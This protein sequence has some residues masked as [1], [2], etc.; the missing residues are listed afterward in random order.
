MSPEL[1][2]FVT[3][4]FSAFLIGLTG[5]IIKLIQFGQQWAEAKIKGELSKLSTSDAKLVEYVATLAIQNIEQLR[6][7]EGIYMSAEVALK[8]AVVDCQMILNNLGMKGID[9]ETI[10]VTVG[11][12]LRQGLHKDQPTI[13][14]LATGL[15]E[16]TTDAST[17]G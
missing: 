8:K 5:L 9:L 14:V 2:N 3:A 7:K 15:K 13:S 6:I 11:A 1:Q 12:M 17:S 4:V 16:G 10:V